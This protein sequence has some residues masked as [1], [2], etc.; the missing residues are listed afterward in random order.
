M[1]LVLWVSL[2]LG[3]WG[4]AYGCASVLAARRSTLERL[5]VTMLV[6]V[7]AILALVMALA[8]AGVCRRAVLASL[9]ALL[10]VVVAGWLSVDR[11]RRQ[12][13][14]R[15]AAHDLDAFARVLVDA[16][17]RR[18]P[19]VLLLVQGAAVVG[20]SSIFAWRMASW[21]WDCA[22]YHAAMT[23][24][25]AQS[26]ALRWEPT[27]VEY[28]NGYPRAVEML[29]VWNEVLLGSKRLDDA[30]QIPFAF[31]GAAVVAACCRRFSVPRA[32][33]AALAAA[34]VALPSVALELHTSHADVAAG[35]LFLTT[36]YFL[37]GPRFAAFEMFAAAT[38]LGLY[39]ATKVTGLFHAALLA[40]VVLG[41]IVH[42]LAVAR[43]PA[44][45]RPLFVAACTA[46]A[47][48]LLLG[49]FTPLRNWFHEGNPLWPARV[50]IPALHLVLPGTLDPATI[51]DP[52][53]FFGA[54]GAVRRM[55]ESW[56]G[57]AEVPFPDIRAGGFG[58]VFPYLTLPVF[59]AALVAALFGVVPRALLVTIPVVL[60]AVVV[61]AAWWGRF[62]LAVP[63][64]AFVAFGVAHRKLRFWP[65]RAIAS[66]AL[67]ALS[68]AGSLRTR[69]GYRFLP[70]AFGPARELEARV[71]TLSWLWPLEAH[72]A[73][74]ADLRAGDAVV[75]DAGV[76]FLDDL[77]AD[78][79][80]NRVRYAECDGDAERCAGS[81]LR[82]DVRW[83]V[84]GTYGL[85]A[86][87]AAA[88]T[89][90]FRREFSVGQG[91][92]VVFRR[93]EARP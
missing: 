29:G 55:V 83:V 37:T 49:G 16:R 5:I 50:S 68:V 8:L 24:T 82:P 40:P 86:Q 56:Y 90:H 85:A 43:T 31:L 64:M 71:R 1:G 3:A 34:W 44:A 27:H 72:E 47:L 17:R 33:S 38:A 65:L 41:R 20:L 67:V 22:W 14:F 2:T 58:L 75:Y 62:T 52:P 19:A 18:E 69:E 76:G 45:R 28:V 54:P 32:M 12:R 25:V 6:G 53:A 74:V 78:D 39:V 42:A 80:R 93:L 89:Q 84:A 30:A 59:V 61:P 77:W 81:L 21:S 13:F 87:T 66:V 4:A 35:A 57:T 7:A 9:S 79:L 26:G 46:P 15:L 63:A 10:E 88:Q 11:V 60:V 91:A 48:A 23:H 51:A 36:I 92:V 73:F 70:E